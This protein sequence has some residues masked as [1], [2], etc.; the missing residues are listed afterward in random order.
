MTGYPS[1]TDLRERISSLRESTPGS[2]ELADA[3]LAYVET[4]WFEPDV[5]EPLVQEAL[6]ICEKTEYRYGKA[7]AQL[8]LAE[9]TYIRTHYQE[10]LPLMLDALPVFIEHDAQREYAWCLLLMAAVSQ[11]TGAYDAALEQAFKALEIGRESG[12]EEVVGWMHY[13]IS[14]IYRELGDLDHMLEFAQGCYDLF[15]DLYS[16]SQRRQHL[17][18]TARAR[19]Q[20]AMAHERLGKL[21]EALQYSEAALDLYRQGRDVLGETRAITDIGRVYAER[22]EYEKAERY[23]RD[24]LER[25]R[26]LGHRASQTSNLLA[27]GDLYLERGDSERAIELFDEALRIAVDSN[28]KMRAYQAHEAL[29]RVY[30][31]IGEPQK[32]F[33]HFGMFHDLK[34]EVAGEAMNLR[35]HNTKVLAEIERAENEAQL[36]R[37][38]SEELRAKNEELARLLDE[39]K[40]TQD[41]LIQSEKMASLGQL[42]AGIAHEIRNPL[43]FVNNFSHLSAEIVD[44]MKEVLQRCSSRLNDEERGELQESLETLLFNTRKIKEHGERADGIV[45]SMLQHSRTGKDER[46]TVDV[47]GLL[48]EYLNLA[49]HGMRARESDFNVTLER[50]FDDSIREIE[51]VRQD[52]GRVFLNLISNAFQALHDHRADIQDPTVRVSTLN[53]GSLVEIRVSDNGPGIPEDVRDKIFEPFFTT[54]PTGMGTGLGLSISYD[55]VTKGHNGSLEVESKRGEGSTFV[56]KLPA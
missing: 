8:A 56:V 5:A 23:L 25:R 16:R 24:G 7:R 51:G 39:L 4:L 52:L 27:L 6:Q 29:S 55:I 50:D 1:E 18:G 36:E 35:I 41:R 34:E 3:I 43:N 47:N 49:Y 12:S 32:A 38:K 26:E 9:A 37:A 13:R 21:D 48:D 2:N 31:E 53:S 45:K 20:L 42:T 54:K 14:D 40:T 46:S 17:I 22:A 19:T 10:S 30:A 15:E 33:E 44:E 11:S 28:V